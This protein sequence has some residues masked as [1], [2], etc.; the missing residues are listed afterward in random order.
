MK[1][2]DRYLLFEALPALIFGL[3]I[4]SSLAVVS[5]I[6]PRLKWIVGTPLKDLSI[7]LLLQMPQALVQTFPIALVLAIL[8][9]FGRLAT[10]NELKA[11]QSGGV[12][13]FRSARVYIILAIFLAASSLYINENILPITNPKIG[14]IYW[15]LTSGGNSGLWRLVNQ[16]I[17]IGNMTLN[18][19]KVDRKTDV[20]YDIR[21]ENWRKKKLYVT[22]AKRAEFVNN[23]I[24][25]YNYQVNILDLDSLNHKEDNAEK[26]LA[27]LVKEHELNQSKEGTVIDIEENIDELITRHSNGGFEDSRSIYKTYLDA[28][29][30]LLKP[31]D[32]KQ[33]AILFHKKLAEP[34]AN[35][36]LL[37]L[38][39]PLSL[40]YASNRG[41]AFG[42]SL[43][44]TLIWYLIFTLGQLF[45]QAN[46][47]PVWLGVWFANI[48]LASIGIYLLKFNRKLN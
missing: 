36:A 47:I 29:N 44:V 6:L 18:F 19:K 28:N 17:P 9:S 45:A 11:I 22:L 13:L 12:S 43:I 30:E 3:L 21:I 48:L 5:T 27:A 16:D 35:I 42:L 23:K 24:R 37:L 25:I 38:A 15:K 40:L 2:L 14:A 33:A 1:R 7:W 8:L 46:A 20:I 31:K 32:R 10:S 4:Y 39:I 34:L 41:L 26:Q